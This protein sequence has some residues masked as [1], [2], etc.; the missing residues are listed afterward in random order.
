M[1]AKKPKIIGPYTPE[2]PGPF[3]TREGRAVR[4]VTRTEGS[5][6]FPVIGLLDGCRTPS[7]W[8]ETGK[9][10]I[11]GNTRNAMDLMNVE[12]VP[13]AREFWVNEYEG[14]FPSLHQ[15]AEEAQHGAKAND[16]LRTIHVCE[17]LVKENEEENENA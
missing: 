15:C 14:H 9:F 4:I 16:F 6:S 2:H 7:A 8:T 5:N 10:I 17:V 13:V 1:T 11:N 3:C 12:E